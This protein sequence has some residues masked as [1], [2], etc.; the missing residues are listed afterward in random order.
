[1]GLTSA[2]TMTTA[3]TLAETIRVLI[4]DD[5]VVVRRL[6]SHALADQA[7][8]EIVGTANGGEAAL[9]RIPQVNPN[10]V[11]LDIEMPDMD[12]LAVLARIRKLHP[13]IRVIMCSVLTTHRAAV[14]LEA[15]MLGA[16]DYIAKPSPDGQL[17]QVLESF[18]KE[19]VPKMRQLFHG[20]GTVAASVPSLRPRPLPVPLL[21]PAKP[22]TIH[23]EVV[24]I[25]VSTGG[26]NA[27]ADLFS[28]L[29]ADFAKPILIV[30]HMPAIFTRLLA[31]RLKNRTGFD[32]VEATDGMLVEPGRA[33]IA[34]GDYHMRLERQGTQVRIRLDQGA[35]ENS[36]RPAVDVL[37][38]SVEKTYGGAVIAVI[39]TGMGQDGLRGVEQLKRSG[40]L[41][42]AQDNKS[43]V[44]WGMPGAIADAGL[45]DAVLDLHAIVPA[46]LREVGN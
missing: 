21:V 30:Q 44:V 45:A 26:P 41:I 46:I 27:L 22:Q 33:I 43:S 36:C 1:M 32:V 11:I 17:A 16:S 38:R 23:R 10:L 14:T 20:A 12:G 24:A 4:V 25:G 15:L 9:Q 34:A 29:P 5:S 40:A 28:S 6:I 8:I 37:F 19:L 35:P 39:L 3:T 13:D 31:E 18:G 42:L 7:G 2:A